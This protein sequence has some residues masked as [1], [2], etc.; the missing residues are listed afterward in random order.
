MYN[1]GTLDIQLGDSALVLTAYE[2]KMYGRLLTVIM[3]AGCLAIPVVGLMMDKYGFP[4][5]SV[6]VVVFGVCWSL[7]LVNDTRE[8]LIPSFVFYTLFRTF[9]FTF[10]FAYMADTMG[11]K[12]FGVLAGLMFVMAG[13]VSLLQ[14][15]LASWATG[16]CHLAVSSTQRMNCDNGRWTFINLIMTLS[17]LASL[18]FCYTDW[19]RRRRVAQAARVFSER[20]RGGSVMRKLTTDASTLKS[21]QAALTAPS[22]KES[23]ALLEKKIGQASKAAPG[24]ATAAGGGG[25]GRAGDGKNARAPLLNKD[26]QEY[27]TAAAAA[28]DGVGARSVSQG[29]AGAAGTGSAYGYAPS[30]M[31][32]GVGASV[33]GVPVPAQGG[34]TKGLR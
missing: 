14:Y 19:V 13:F 26:Y 3:A 30:V 34:G 32:K 24:A 20:A 8:T 2:Q 33:D 25:G 11:F 28:A 23:D 5:T 10:L 22:D 7:L 12:Y 21:A 6:A 31:L 15:P 17:L 16:T 1:P 27:G 9:L 18:S 29:G 4:I